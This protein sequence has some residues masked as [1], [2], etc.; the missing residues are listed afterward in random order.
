MRPHGMNKLRGELSLFVDRL[1]FHEKRFFSRS[2]RIFFVAQNQ[3]CLPRKCSFANSMSCT[4]SRVP[5]YLPAPSR[6]AIYFTSM[7]R[8]LFS[9]HTSTR[10]R[11]PCLKSSM[12][13]R[14]MGSIFGG[15][16]EKTSRFSAMR[17]RLKTFGPSSK[18]RLILS[19]STKVISMGIVFKRAVSCSIVRRPPGMTISPSAALATACVAFSAASQVSPSTPKQVA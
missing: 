2:R 6:T 8:P 3:A 16:Q 17:G 15:W 5:R 19:A 7:V 9:I 14:T 12:I 11:R 10:S 4:S 13:E 1:Q 18:K